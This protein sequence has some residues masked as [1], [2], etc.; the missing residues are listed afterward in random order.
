MEPVGPCSDGPR[1][2]H[3]PVRRWVGDPK[4]QSC[5]HKKLL[6]AD[7]GQPVS[8]PFAD[9]SRPRSRHTCR[10]RAAEVIPKLFLCGT[11]AF[12][13]T[14]HP[15]HVRL[16][17][18]AQ[19]SAS[20]TQ[21]SASQTD[22][23]ITNPDQFFASKGAIHEDSKPRPGSRISS[24]SCHLRPAGAG[25]PGRRRKPALRIAGTNGV[26]PI[27]PDPNTGRHRHPGYALLQRP[28]RRVQAPSGPFAPGTNVVLVECEAPNGVLPTKTSECDPGNTQSADSIIANPSGGFTYSDYQLYALP[29]TGGELGPS[30]ITCGDSV[31][32]ECVVGMFADYNGFTDPHALL[33]ALLI[34]PIAR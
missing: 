24:G 13:L 16:H 5:G 27:N 6:P 1:R 34:V 31:A 26:Q 3:P 12:S 20:R 33:P 10:L 14:R 25:R 11:W 8:G 7:P 22:I 23:S 19:W 32:T 18:S 21:E 4:A 9:R 2:W 29:D 15:S 28:D 30:T 17:L